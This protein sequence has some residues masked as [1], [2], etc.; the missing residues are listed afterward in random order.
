MVHEYSLCYFLY[1]CICLKLINNINKYIHTNLYN[2]TF[3]YLYFQ[4]W[5]FPPKLQTCIFNCLLNIST[6][7]FNSHLRLNMSKMNSGSSPSSPQP[8]PKNTSPRIFLLYKWHYIHPVV[9]TKNFG[10]ILP[11]SFSYKPHP[12]PSAKCSWN[13]TS[14]H[15]L[16]CYHPCLSFVP[17][18]PA[19]AF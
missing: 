13:Q 11:S 14:S 18:V 4:P 5:L 1:F 10:V 15:C 17:W 6:W 12:I 3:L 19:K 8:H 16:Y 7:L 2:W 9:Q